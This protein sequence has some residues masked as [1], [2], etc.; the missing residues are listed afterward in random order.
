[1]MTQTPLSAATRDQRGVARPVRTPVLP[2]NPMI[3]PLNINSL[4]PSSTPLAQ[5]HPRKASASSLKNNPGRSRA[6]LAQPHPRKPSSLEPQT[7][8]L[9]IL[10]AN[11]RLEFHSTHRKISLLKIPNRERIAILQFTPQPLSRAASSNLQNGNPSGSAPLVHPEL[12]RAQ[13]HSRKLFFTNHQTRVTSHEF[14]IYG[15]A[16]RN[17]RK[18]LKT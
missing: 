14:L 6:P 3:T 4:G 1:M 17:R 8:S 12:R 16:I 7:S 11:A 9:Q 13:P 5:L 2:P 18:A 10:I 15:S